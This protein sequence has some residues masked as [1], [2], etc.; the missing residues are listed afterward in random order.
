M[1]LRSVGAIFMIHV[2]KRNREERESPNL[3]LALKLAK[4]ESIS[5]MKEGISFPKR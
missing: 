1:S 3:K 4:A 2:L 5:V